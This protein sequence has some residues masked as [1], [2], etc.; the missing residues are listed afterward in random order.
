MLVVLPAIIRTGI[1]RLTLDPFGKRVRGRH[2]KVAITRLAVR[3]V[4]FPLFCAC[5]RARVTFLFS[6]GGRV[7]ANRLKYAASL[8]HTSSAAV[9]GTVGPANR[10]DCPTAVRQHSSRQLVGFSGTPV[11]RCFFVCCFGERYHLGTGL[12]CFEW[13]LLVFA[14]CVREHARTH[15]HVMFANFHTILYF[16]CTQTERTNA[17]V[18]LNALAHLHGQTVGIYGFR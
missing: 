3:F 11:G 4:I 18:Q 7:R 12:T 14:G 13:L 10:Y 9:L 1:A 15:T 2:V 16:W 6:S 8:G 17:M 5:E